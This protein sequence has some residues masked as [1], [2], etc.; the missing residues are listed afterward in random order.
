MAIYYDFC[1]RP[2]LIRY[3]IYI[4]LCAPTVIFLLFHSSRSHVSFSFYVSRL[5][6]V[7]LEFFAFLIITYRSVTLN[8]C[9]IV[10]GAPMKMDGGTKVWREAILQNIN[11]TNVMTIEVCGETSG[12]KGTRKTST[13]NEKS[14][15]NVIQSRHKFLMELKF[16][17]RIGCGSLRSCFFLACSHSLFSLFC[18]SFSFPLC[19]SGSIPLSYTKRNKLLPKSRN[20]PTKTEKKQKK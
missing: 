14:V 4:R 12:N 16:S 1:T 9:V 19:D 5:F 7:S 13:W 6:W 20:F 11:R 17:L 18:F 2:S 10:Y 15:W 3:I 8:F